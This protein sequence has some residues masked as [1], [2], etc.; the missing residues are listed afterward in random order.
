[1]GN[2]FLLL[3]IPGPYEPNTEELNGLAD[4]FVEQVKVLGKGELLTLHATFPE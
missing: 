1:M 4:L 2:M 3:A